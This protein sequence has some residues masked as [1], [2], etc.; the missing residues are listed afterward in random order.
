KDLR[1]V[2]DDLG[3]ERRLRAG[4][5]EPVLALTALDPPADR[6][7]RGAEDGPAVRARDLDRHGGP[8]AARR[9]CV[10]AT[11]PT[12]GRRSTGRGSSRH[13]PCAGTGSGTPSVPTTL[14]AMSF[15]FFDP[16]A[17]L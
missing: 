4:D 8:R 3:R 16:N 6:L 17:A 12:G 2:L 9:G 15:N 13:T 10:R 7:V 14:M 5:G 11:Y 1:L